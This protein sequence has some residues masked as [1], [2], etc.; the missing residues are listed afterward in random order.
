MENVLKSYIT[1]FSSPLPNKQIL[2]VEIYP[3]VKISWECMFKIYMTIQYKC[4]NINK[5]IESLVFYIHN[6][7]IVNS[8]NRL[9]D[10]CHPTIPF[11]LKCMVV[12]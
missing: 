10:L 6:K 12:N 8:I 2:H 3:G 5:Q 11:E 4:T 7:F 1:Y 9:V